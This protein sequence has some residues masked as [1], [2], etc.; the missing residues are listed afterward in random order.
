[1][2]APA[3]RFAAAA[4]A[5]L[6]AALACAAPLEVTVGVIG[7]N[8][9]GARSSIVSP[10]VYHLEKTLPQY[11]FR[12]VDIPIFQ[13]VDFVKRTKP[14]LVVGPSDIFFT[15]INT[16]GAQAIA[17]R[18]NIWAKDGSASVGSSVI[19][20]ADNAGIASLS[21]LKDRRI[22]ASLPDSLGGWLAFAGEMTRRGLSVK[23]LRE[24]TNFV[25]YEFPAVFQS[26]LDGTAD[27]GV[28]TACQLEIAEQRG[29]VEPGLLR[30]VGEK[31]TDAISCKVSTDLYP[32]QIFGVLNF[33]R[34]AMIK[35][36]AQALLSMPPQRDY[37]WQ[38]A[39]R[40]HEVA[41]LYEDLQTGPFAKKPWTLMDFLQRYLWYLVAALSVV[42]LLVLNEI[43]LKKL[44]DRRTAAL[45]R[46]LERNR[47]LALENER[48]AEHLAKVERNSLVSHMGTMIAHELKQPLATITNYCEVAKIRLENLDEPELESLTNSL[49]SEIRRIS[50]I[51]DRVRAYARR[52]G[53]AHEPLDL[54]EVAAEALASFRTYREFRELSPVVS[55]DFG[56]GC[57]ILGDR[58]EL[59][60]LV[61]NLL[62]NGARAA[63]A[64]KP[65]ALRIAVRR[66]PDAVLLEISDNGPRLSAEE[67]DRLHHASD[68]TDPEGLGLGLSIVRGI[69]DS[70]SAQLSVNQLPD[71]G[72]CFAFRFDLC[73]D[74]DNRKAGE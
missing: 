59:E 23:K 24:H 36:V 73:P 68:S 5:F 4:A 44:V 61:I 67:F 20:R 15:L 18:K 52:S 60:I 34:P 50:G 72:I 2:K 54:S 19:V 63:A 26:V 16:A 55:T 74:N 48:T 66:L 21:D 38:V 25:T 31:P 41:R 71:K 69:A 9:L 64:Q 17:T 6:F 39:G 46:S 40:F 58:L 45:S 57:R 47:R 49:Q 43:R 62:K 3:P 7:S 30:V 53:A 12:P 1:M 35:E 51:V 42:G 10:T 65:P 33:S 13:A 28:L 11:R 32:G 70:H 14:D 56:T 27:A 37:E 8:D 29:M 22:A